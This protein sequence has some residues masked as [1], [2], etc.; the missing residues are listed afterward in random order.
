MEIE[1][2]SA[3][4]RDIPPDYVG[5]FGIVFRRGIAAEPSH[6][7]DV[8]GAVKQRKEEHVGGGC[9]VA[10]LISGRSGDIFH[11]LE[12]GIGYSYCP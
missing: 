5:G 3:L 1:H 4:Y 6:G 8:H 7:I 12:F 2:I 10:G 11:A 9:R